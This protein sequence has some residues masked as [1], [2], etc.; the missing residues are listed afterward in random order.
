LKNF[1]IVKKRRMSDNFYKNPIRRFEI[2]RNYSGFLAKKQ[3][4]FGNF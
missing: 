4:F 3:P 1:I 2:F